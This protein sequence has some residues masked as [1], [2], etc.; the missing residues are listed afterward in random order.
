MA[1]LLS[2]LWVPI[3]TPFDGEGRIDVAAL[4]HLAQ[5]LLAD[6]C[7]GLVALGT[8]GEPATLTP[9][10]RHVVVDT[11]AAACR[12]AGRRL[13]IGVGSNST[14]ST[15][16]E[17]V[18]FEASHRATALLVVV[19]YYTRPS[20]AGIVEHFSAVAA[21]V[22]TPRVVYNVPYR[23]GRSID[24]DLL[25]ALASIPGV[26]GVKQAVGALDADTLDL[27]GRKPESFAVLSGDDAFITPTILMGGAGAVAAAAHLCAPRFL[28]M[29]AAA[30]DGNVATAR[31]LAAELSAVVQHGFAEPN[32]AAWKGALSALGEINTPTLRSPMTAA[33]AT[34]VANL[35]A[36]AGR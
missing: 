10:E 2:G 33:S 35:L 15:I 21:A 6:G 19:P 11:C 27:L 12:D 25:L 5:R 7:T 23:T 28:Q 18:E 17:A 14:A 34:A 30:L 24:V 16:E 4:A 9:R 1:H 31:A 22:R 29:T 3:V 32:P 13:M 36:A 20:A 8:T 26:I